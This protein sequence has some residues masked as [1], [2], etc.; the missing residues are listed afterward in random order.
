MARFCAR[1]RQ[2]A[3]MSNVS[4]R[5]I[6]LNPT[7]AKLAE[8]L[9]HTADETVATAKR[10]PF[11]VPS[12]L[13]YYGCGALQ[14]LFYAVS[15]L[16]GLRFFDVGL[17]WTYE[18]VDD[19]SLPSQRDG[20]GGLLRRADRHPHRREVDADRTMGGSVHPDPSSARTRSCWAIGRNPI[21]FIPDRSRSAA[22]RSS[23]KP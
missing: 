1:I 18:A 17:E 7:V 6:Y 12:N 15:A 16:L 13:A 11:H 20:R 8:R 19:E 23:A 21:S 14:L 22:M 5:D 3:G 2:R 4:M 9:G 10:E